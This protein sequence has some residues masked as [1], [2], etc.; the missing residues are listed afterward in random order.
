MGRPIFPS[1][2]TPTVVIVRLLRPAR[3]HQL[4]R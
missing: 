2:M 4:I 3:G 1:P